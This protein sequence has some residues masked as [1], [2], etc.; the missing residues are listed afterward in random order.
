MFYKKESLSGVGSFFLCS[1]FFI[2]FFVYTCKHII[3]L[4]T[5]DRLDVLNLIIKQKK[6]KTYL[7]I[8][9]QTGTII[10]KVQCPRKIGVD[11]E[12][13]F[14][15]PLKIKRLLGISKFETFECTSDDFFDQQANRVLSDGIDVALVDGLH[16]YE[17]AKRDVEHCLSYLNEGG[18]IVMHDCN[19]L[20]EAAAYRIK[21][22]F[23]EVRE[24]VKNWDLPGWQ[25]QWNGDVWKTVADLIVTRPDLHVFTL[26]M[27]YGLG[28]VMKG[29]R[30]IHV[31][32]TLEEVVQGDYAFFEKNRMELLNLKHP[33]YIKELMGA[34]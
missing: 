27:D 18:V 10:S 7:E 16:T 9:V 1:Y 12:F 11:P 13:L 5:M 33:K 4:T 8:G 17:Q 24:K 20:N 25:G 32:F 23:N 21:E 3:S 28:V 2:Y 26:D 34:L 19:P 15:I 6:A 29:E 22:H 30:E 31:P 14:S